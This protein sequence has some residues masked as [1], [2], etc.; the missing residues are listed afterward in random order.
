[1]CRESLSGL[2]VGP[3]VLPAKLIPG[4]HVAGVTITAG[5]LGGKG[6]IVIV[7]HEPEILVIDDTPV[8]LLDEICSSN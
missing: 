7:H 3:A 4:V 2:D 6:V 8:W 5:F 1:M